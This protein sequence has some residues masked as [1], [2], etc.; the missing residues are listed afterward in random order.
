MRHQSAV[1]LPAM[2]YICRSA[3][4]LDIGATGSADSELDAQFIGAAA[5]AMM[6]D[7]SLDMPVSVL[8]QPGLNVAKKE[9]ESCEGRG[10][11]DIAATA[12][13]GREFTNVFRVH[14]VRE[15]D[16]YGG[17]KHRYQNAL[18]FSNV[19]WLWSGFFRIDKLTG[20]FDTESLCAD[21]NRGGK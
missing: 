2:R 17:K 11:S 14:R 15:P 6:L 5:R 9:I 16:A 8:Q 19:A 18:H 21:G 3:D 10:A 20:W 7:I 4:P 12:R 1:A 13:L